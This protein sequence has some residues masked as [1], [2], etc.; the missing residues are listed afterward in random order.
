MNLPDI[1]RSW[2]GQVE[3]ELVCRLSQY[4]RGLD[5][6]LT[7]GPKKRILSLDGGGIRG[8]MAIGVLEGIEDLLRKRHGNDPDFRLCDY[9]DLIGGT[10][11]G[12]IIAAAL[13][14]KRFSASEIKDFYFELSP[15]IFRPSLLRQGFS[16][17]KFDGSR[18][19]N[20]LDD[21]FGDTT[22]GDSSLESGI[23]I[24][25]KRIDTSSTWVMHNNPSAPFFGDPADGSYIGNKHY[26]LKNIIRASTAAPHYFKPERIEIIKDQEY[27]LFVDGGMTPHNNPAFQLVMLVGMN[28]HGYNWAFGA[29]QLLVTSIGT[30]SM[31]E[32]VEADKV[33]RQLQIQKT[34]QALTSMITSSEDF[35]ELLMQWLG[36]SSDPTEIDSE[37]GTLAQEFLAQKPLFSYQRYQ[38]TL[39][40]SALKSDLG[41]SISA[42]ELSVLRDMTD[43]AATGIA[44]GVGQI[45]ADK[46]IKETH[47]PTGFDL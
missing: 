32:R 25:A 19:L 23:A 43:P 45:M 40:Q 15:K 3:N 26:L 11:T 24:V 10:S 30:G 4:S 18:L 6:K 42:K 13:V 1:V 2:F 33:N 21:V 28:G 16:R 8:A 34:M 38:A 41:I 44:H 14:A 39:N 31:S 12:S 35:V 5:A 20:A 36:E 37:I 17:A 22:L 7:P 47:F 46:L 29:D 9:Y 27:G